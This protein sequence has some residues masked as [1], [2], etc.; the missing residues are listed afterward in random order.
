MKKTLLYVSQELIWLLIAAVFAVMLVYPLYRKVE[1]TFLTENLLLAFYAIMLLRMVVFFHGVIWLKPLWMRFLMFVINLNLFFLIIRK[2]Q[3]FLTI[4][5]SFT[6]E[7]LGKPKTPL[8]LSQME[9]LFHYFYYE[10]NMVVISCLVMIVLFCFRLIHSYW[11]LR[12]TRLYVD[13]K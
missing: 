4:Y 9:K 3:N 7:D 10:I 13:P 8:S 1:Y 6:M 12:K 5:D 2:E 11:S